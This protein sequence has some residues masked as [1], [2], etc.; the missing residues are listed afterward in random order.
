MLGYRTDTATSDWEI[1][2]DETALQR[3][4]IDGWHQAALELVRT[5][6]DRKQQAWIDTWHADRLR[7]IDEQDARLRVGH[8]DLVAWL[9]EY[10]KAP[11][12]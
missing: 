4:L 2:P 5:R 9:D 3:A 8:R 12:H 6:M 10:G 11:R 7:M 1:G